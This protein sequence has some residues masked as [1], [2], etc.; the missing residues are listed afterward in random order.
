MITFM[1]ITEVELKF[2]GIKE[3][4]CLDV[5]GFVELPPTTVVCLYVSGQNFS[6][7]V[8]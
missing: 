4:D 6:F 2:S 3:G 5:I 7:W 1:W 8:G